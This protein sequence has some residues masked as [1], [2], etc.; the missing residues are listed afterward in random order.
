MTRMLVGGYKGSGKTEFCESL[1]KGMGI[2][3]VDTSELAVREILREGLLPGYSDYEQVQAVKGM[4]RPE[5]YQAIDKYNTPQKFRMAQHVL[6]LCAIYCGMR[7]VDE[8]TESSWLFD[9]TIWIDRPGCSE[10]D[11]S[12][13]VDEEHFILTV[14]NTGSLSELQRKAMDIGRALK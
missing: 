1:A 9:L 7:S 4:I 2:D 6:G 10:P 12:C 14:K 11:S 8:L 5:L 3:F 13:T